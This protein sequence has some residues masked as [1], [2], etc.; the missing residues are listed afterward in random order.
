MKCQ[1]IPIDL[2]LRREFIVAGAKTSVK[3]NYVFIIDNIG[4]GEAAGSIHYGAKNSDIE[5]ELNRI[6]DDL[7]DL[8]KSEI[9][10]YLLTHSDRYSRPALCAVSTAW[11]D[12]RGK[13]DDKPLHLLL[14]FNPMK[15]IHTSVT[16][17]LGDMA[18]LNLLIDSGYDLI[19]IKMDADPKTADTLRAILRQN[20]HIKVRIDANG[21]WT[22]ERAVDMVNV[23]PLEN[24]DLIEQ[25]FPCDAVE[26]W[27]GFKELAKMPVIMDEGIAAVKDIKKVAS[28]VDG[29]NIKI[30]K[31]G[32][33]ETAREAIKC[34]RETGLKVMLGCMIESSVGIATACHLAALADYYDLDGRWLVADDPFIGLEYKMASPKISGNS[35]HGIT[36]A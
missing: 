19:K 5:D 12:W 11:Y 13:C 14:G 32:L 26:D 3:R 22:F 33:L 18:G 34:A 31:S 28:Y 15:N 17:S 24:I 4:I 9:S 27:K 7:K 23:L 2:K 6:K 30:Q 25:P 35:G 10:N 16:A 29:I 8:N 20:P 36:F 21:S 1:I